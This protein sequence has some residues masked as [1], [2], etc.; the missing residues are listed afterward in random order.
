MK[1]AFLALPGPMP[2]KVVLA[3]IILVVFLVVLFAVYD[4]MGE[5][6]LDTGGGIG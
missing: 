2:V 6:L 4:W 3:I 1:S 5:N